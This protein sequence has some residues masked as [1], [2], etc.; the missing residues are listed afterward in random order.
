MSE[1]VEQLRL[2]SPD[3]N[4]PIIHAQMGICVNCHKPIMMMVNNPMA[5]GWNHGHNGNPDCDAARPDDDALEL[6]RKVMNGEAI[7]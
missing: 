6:A 3:E 1:Q 5:P 4:V 7:E 2:A